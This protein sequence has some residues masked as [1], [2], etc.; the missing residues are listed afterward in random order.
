M[1]QTKKENITKEAAKKR[2]ERFHFLLPY[3]NIFLFVTLLF[4]LVYLLNLQEH[5]K[6]LQGYMLI[7][8][9]IALTVLTFQSFRKGF[10]WRYAVQVFM[11]IGFIM[12]IGYMLYTPY[13][14]RAFDL[15]DSNLEGY[16]HA[17]YILTLLVKKQ[18]PDTNWVQFYHPPLFHFL[19]ACL[20][21]A[22]NKIMEYTKYQDILEIAKIISCVASCWTLMLLTRI[23]SELKLS[24]QVKAIA[25][26]I[27]AVLPSCYLMAG[28]INND[29]LVTYFMILAILYTIKWYRNQSWANT[30][31]L[32]L[33]FGLGMMTKTSCGNIALFTGPLMLYVGYKRIKEKNWRGI[34]LKFLGFGSIAFPLGLWYTVRNYILFSQPFGY[35]VRIDES[36]RI[37]TGDVSWIKRF[38]EFPVSRLFFPEYSD[39]WKEYNISIFLI[40][41]S[42]FSEF[43]FMINPAI[44]ALLILFNFILILFSLVAMVYVM[45]KYKKNRMVRFGMPALWL[46][47]MCS[48]IYFNISYPFGCTMDFRYIVPTAFIGAICIGLL[49][50][51]S[52]KQR[53]VKSLMLRYGITIALSM[54]ALLSVLMFCLNAY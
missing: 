53:S 41:S 24:D 32:A 43:K 34:V 50:E 30:I 17:A 54:F 9:L 22:V 48:Y 19:A 2:K 25:T 45:V 33:A 47:I 44:P 40:K 11:A 31:A 5:T 4:I 12:R 6:L 14:T 21:G 20:C 15:G 27:I 28:R 23:C 10:S 16:G 7:G 18:L 37:Y 42:L 35:V 1:E 51:K 46:V 39:P 38:L 49:F 29:A 8:V 13:T 36:L 52:C 26:A 3:I